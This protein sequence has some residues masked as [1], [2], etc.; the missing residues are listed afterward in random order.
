MK[1]RKHHVP[2]KLANNSLA[3]RTA[4]VHTIWEF[5]SAILHLEAAGRLAL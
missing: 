4:D 3:G 5:G 2:A 1:Y